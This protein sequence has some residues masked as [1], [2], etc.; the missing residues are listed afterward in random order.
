MSR[1]AIALR[2]SVSSPSMALID[3]TNVAS[4]NNL[5]ASGTGLSDVSSPFG[6]AFN[7]AVQMA[8]GS[9]LFGTD[10]TA[11]VSGADSGPYDQPLT[12]PSSGVIPV[13]SPAGAAFNQAA[14]F[15]AGASLSGPPGA[16]N[17]QGAITGPFT[18]EGIVTLSATDLADG[19]A[20]LFRWEPSDQGGVSGWELYYS[21]ANELQ[22]Y[23]QN[24]SN[25]PESISAAWTPTSGT[26]YWVAVTWDGT[27]FR[28]FA[29]GAL[30]VTSS[31]TSVYTPLATGYLLI[32]GTSGSTIDEIRI[33]DVA[34]YTAS[35]TPAS[36][37]FTSDSDTG[38]LYHLDGVLPPQDIGAI[39]TSAFTAEV[40]YEPTVADLG[41][42]GPLVLAAC[43]DSVSAL[44][45][46]WAI[47]YKPGAGLQCALNWG[48]SGVVYSDAVAV[49]AGS[50]YATALVWTGTD[51]LWFV[52]GVQVG[53]TI[54]TGPPA[55]PFS[56]VMVVAQATGS[57]ASGI[58]DEIRLSSTARYS[59]NYTPATAPFSLDADTI[60]LWHLDAQPNIETSLVFPSVPV[61]RSWTGAIVIENTAP[62][63]TWKLR[64]GNNV[65]GA[66]TGSGPY[67]PVQAL[68][69]EQITLT[70]TDT[71][72]ASP[73][74]ATVVA[75]LL[76][77][78]ADIH[79]PDLSFVSPFAP[80]GLIASA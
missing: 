6:A 45:G 39:V 30:L 9:Y 80:S 29:N 63:T 21:S 44:V 48:K 26:A 19:R 32:N 42:T 68:S 10:Y 4:D 77:E 33:S 34:R 38:C 50:S 71:P 5:T 27:Y 13:A 61:G 75:Y 20:L 11:T 58:V 18:A 1:G 14:E 59:A 60:A 2:E 74:G 55:F 52:N 24:A 3:G 53:S 41:S 17:A 65:W 36:A 31:A 8:H 28:L 56:S 49:R 43:L 7:Q 22:L 66:I 40:L 35:Y 69:G 72:S 15:T 12:V 64:I 73:P 37:P 62:T 67:G 70:T 16:T 47:I 23:W 54:A 79:S 51:L 46:D 78:N 25:L 57:P 76:G